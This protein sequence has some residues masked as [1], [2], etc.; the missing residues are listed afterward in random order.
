MGGLPVRYV[1]LGAL[2]LSFASAAQAAN[3]SAKDPSGIVRLLQE[4]GYKAELSNDETG[5]IIKSADSGYNF[6]IFFLNCDQGKNCSTIQFYAGFNDVEGLE[7]TR[8][9]EWNK[10]KRFARAYIDDEA[11]PVIELD[12]DLDFQ[13]IPAENFLEILNTWTSLVPAF[14][15]FVSEKE[16]KE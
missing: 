14:A 16:T 6:M 4:K 12:L 10:T 9:N 3:V 11:D 7:L 15:R 1:F 13:G 5:P 8:I 2:A